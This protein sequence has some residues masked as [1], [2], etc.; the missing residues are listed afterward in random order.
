MSNALQEHDDVVSQLRALAVDAALTVCA[1]PDLARAV[2]ARGRT[3]RAAQQLR[4]IM[5]RNVQVVQPESSVFEAA[6]MMR[7][8]NVGFLPVCDGRRLEGVIT[9]RDIVIRPI[10]DSRDPQLTP[11]RDAMSPQLVY[12]YDG[13][14]V[15]HAAELMRQ[16]QIRRLPIVDHNKH[17]VG[18]VSLGDLAVDAGNDRLSGATLERIS[19]P[20]RPGR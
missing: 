8:L 20:S 14:S 12:A 13:D 5:T 18:I 19:E 7:R 6:T 15:E 16:H 9:D 4:S 1:K 11:V 10:A 3:G 2:L 17:L